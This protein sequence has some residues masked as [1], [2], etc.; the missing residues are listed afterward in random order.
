ML[1]HFKRDFPWRESL[2]L[3]TRL[4]NIIRSFEFYADRE[5]GRDSVSILV[6]LNAEGFEAAKSLLGIS[7]VIISPSTGS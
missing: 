7:D 1:P 4:G 2:V 5:Y 6:A 3:P